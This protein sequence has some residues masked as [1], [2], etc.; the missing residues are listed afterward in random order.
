MHIVVTKSE[1]QLSNVLMD[2]VCTHLQHTNVR[3]VLSHSSSAQDCSCTAVTFSSAYFSAA[4]L[5]YP[6]IV[7]H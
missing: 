3:S 5:G 4:D 7:L 6:C 1:C 2:T